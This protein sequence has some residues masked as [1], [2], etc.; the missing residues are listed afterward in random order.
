MEFPS[1]K[2]KSVHKQITENK[3]TMSN[4]EIKNKIQE[5]SEEERCQLFWK[6]DET[7]DLVKDVLL[8]EFQIW[9]GIEALF[10]G[11]YSNTNVLDGQ[12][13]LI[14][15][16]TEVGV[17][18]GSLNLEDFR[19]IVK[20]LLTHAIKYDLVVD[21]I[22]E[23]II[24][25]LSKI[26]TSNEDIISKLSTLIRYVGLPP[27]GFDHLLEKL[28]KNF[29]G[30]NVEI[31]KLKELPIDTCQ[32]Y[33]EYIDEI[34]DKLDYDSSI[35]VLKQWLDH[36]T[37]NNITD[38]KISQFIE[39]WSPKKDDSNIK[40]FQNLETERREQKISSIPLAYNTF[41]KPYS[42]DIQPETVR[43][44]ELPSNIPSELLQ[45]ISYHT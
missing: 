23:T 17:Y 37:L 41:V 33:P 6:F 9:K 4:Q 10:K 42:K 7:K 15:T 8:K 35:Q 20:F 32:N 25:L 40:F 18:L 22:N 36:S 34:T 19:S 30:L 12:N 13:E 27:A 45:N 16:F 1:A 24:R 39:N 28:L 11:D 14:L 31:E 3:D 26:T 38:K 29:P 2:V 44:A 43:P 21:E 5:L